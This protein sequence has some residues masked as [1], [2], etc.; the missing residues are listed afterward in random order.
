MKKNILVY[1]LLCFCSV[2]G[3]EIQFVNAP[4]GLIIRENSNI[5]S[6]RIGKLNFGERVYILQKTNIKFE[7]EDNGTT[8]T[9][10][11]NKIKDFNGIQKGFVFSGFL[12]PNVPN[13]GDTAEKYY[14]TTIPQSVRDKY[15]KNMSTSNNNEILTFHLRNNKHEN[16]HEFSISNLEFYEN[17]SV[18]VST[19]N[20][21]EN[22]LKV[23]IVEVNY[24]SCCSNHY[25]TYLLLNNKENLIEIPQI[26]NMHCDGPEPYKTYI[27]PEEENGEENKILLAKITPKTK[28]E[29]GKTEILKKY[30]WNGVTLSEN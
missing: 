6:A 7:F 24:D 16:L 5:N 20:N 22:V 27:F 30:T 4:N 29:E 13:L 10:F 17:S 3:Q 19:V 14:L 15:W 12:T 11:W 18:S 23:I 21:L 8:I 28:K 1:L 26:K 2:Y 25:S 9:G